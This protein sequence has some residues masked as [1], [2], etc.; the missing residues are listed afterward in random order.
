MNR[1][2]I[3][4]DEPAVD[5]LNAIYQA[6]RADH[7]ASY[8]TALAMLGSGIAYGS[9]AVA[10]FGELA[11]KLS[12]LVLTLL[13]FPLWMIAIYHSLVAAAAMTRG[14]SLRR[15]ERE[16]LHRARVPEHE[17]SLLGFAA[18]DPVF[19]VLTASWPHR[20][21]TFVCYAGIGVVTIGGTAFMLA[22]NDRLADPV[23]L[24]T[25]LAYLGLGAVLVSSWVSAILRYRNH[26]NADRWPKSGKE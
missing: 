8:A 5:I 20:L 1:W 25:A 26:V 24:A 18:V 23:R 21:A 14:V 9:A 6:E 11:A 10:F 13:P 4:N 15:L 22:Q 16:L 7:S 19:N 2:R 12:P 3:V 17:R